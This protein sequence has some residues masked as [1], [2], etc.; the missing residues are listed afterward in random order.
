MK[1]F[2]FKIGIWGVIAF[3]ILNGI[4]FLSLYSLG[5]SCLYKPQYVENGVKETAFDYV[6]LGSSTGLTTLDTK[7]IDSLTGKKG[8]NISIDDTSMSTHYVMLQHFYAQ[9]KKTKNLVLTITPWDVAD[10]VPTMS[11]ND[12]RFLTNVKEDY[13][14]NYYKEM[15]KGAFK[16][17]T[18]S[19]Y[20][21]L[22][23]VSYY[24]TEIFYPSV[25]TVVKTEKRNRFDE[26]G[27]YFYPE[28]GAGVK[29]GSQATVY[30]SKLKNPYFE[31]LYAFCKTQNITLILY[32][33]PMY[34][35]EIHYFG[36]PKEVKFIDH[37]RLLAADEFYDNI[38]VN[39]KGRQKASSELTDLVLKFN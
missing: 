32:Q 36:F 14:Y 24:N 10:S 19:R 16:M 28:S 7:Q 38:H 5:K 4:A 18:L 3:A 35:S 12:Y 39:K 8:F 2:L 34:N 25:M 26:K 20:F 17:M 30:H 15:E 11:D 33:S 6:V 27:N 29:A 1:R 13:V 9:G 21:P 37:S 23:G 22:F 31:K